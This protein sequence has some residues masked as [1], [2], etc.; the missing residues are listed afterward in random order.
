MSFPMQVYIKSRKYKI[1][2]R[3]VA[4]LVALTIEISN[5]NYLNQMIQHEFGYSF[6]SPFGVGEN[7]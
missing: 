6:P 5:E 3:D 7:E 1:D 2:I 4:A